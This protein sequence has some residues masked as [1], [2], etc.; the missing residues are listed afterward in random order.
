MPLER[1]CRGDSQSSQDPGVWGREGTPMHVQS[2]LLKA[3]IVGGKRRCRGD[4]GKR[5]AFLT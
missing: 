1:D 2:A 3:V 4:K 5:W